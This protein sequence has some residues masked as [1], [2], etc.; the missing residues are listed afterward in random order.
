MIASGTADDLDGFP[1][2]SYCLPADVGKRHEGPR[3]AQA[4]VEESKWDGRLPPADVGGP[5]G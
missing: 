4:K 5:E 2:S 3:L 1:T